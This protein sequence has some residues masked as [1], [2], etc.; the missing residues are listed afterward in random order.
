MTNS[1]LNTPQAE[2]AVAQNAALKT[3]KP[4]IVSGPAAPGNR[5]GT[6]A[7]FK[8][9]AVAGSKEYTVV[10]GKSWDGKYSST[11]HGTGSFDATRELME[12]VE[13][14][15]TFL[16]AELDWTE[17]IEKAKDFFLMLDTAEA[18]TKLMARKASYAALAEWTTHVI[19]Q[20]PSEL[21]FKLAMT[22]DEWVASSADLVALVATYTA[23]DT[24]VKTNV[25]YSVAATTRRNRGKVDMR[26]G[27]QRVGQHDAHFL[28]LST[29]LTA[30][31]AELSSRIENH[32]AEIARAES[33]KAMAV[34]LKERFAGYKFKANAGTN[35]A[36]VRLFF[37]DSEYTSYL[38]L[39]FLVSPDGSEFFL[40]TGVNCAEFPIARLDEIVAPFKAAILGQ[41]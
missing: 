39:R 13:G 31:Q 15:R 23:K 14:A 4:I 37:K 19:G 12:L 16:G 24:T 7:I 26:Y 40:L 3:I 20:G 25:W 34:R 41:E 9:M 22:E 8:V 36:A 27:F 30:L 2:Q 18:A 33:V 29:M 17:L 35:S 1:N 28:K 5:R 21:S 10:I 32:L 6:A 11:E 38:D